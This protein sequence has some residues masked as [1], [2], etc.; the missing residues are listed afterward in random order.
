MHRFKNILLFVGRESENREAFDRAVTVA[1]R[2]RGEL[3][4]VTVIDRWPLD[5]E[6]M[7][8]VM[9]LWDVQE[10]VSQAASEQLEKLT[11]VAG[12][13]RVRVGARVLSGTPFLEITRAV[14]REQYDLVV[15]TA[16]GEGGLRQPLFGSTSLHLMRKCP[17]PVWVIKPG[18]PNRFSRILA[19]VDTDPDTMNE[20]QDAMNRKIM[21]LATSLAQREQSQLHI[22]H[23]WT[24]SGESLLRSPRT[25]VRPDQVDQWAREDKVQHRQPL[26]TLLAGY[27]LEESDHRVHLIKG[28]PGLVIPVLAREQQIDLI[29]MG[30]VCRTGIEGVLVGNTAERV[31]QQVDCSVLTVKPDG[32]CSPVKLEAS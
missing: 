19:A 21:D 24:M 8:E 23:A 3:T 30:S 13:D 1:E 25:K 22:V 17:C 10:L 12:G 16:E 2:N 32:V 4:A 31:L 5:A 7:A 14:L 18:Q 28:K 11:G 9:P 6:R 15:M 29:V 27:A 26:H 20:T